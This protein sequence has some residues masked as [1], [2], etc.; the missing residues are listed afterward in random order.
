MGS[1][2][3]ARE[4]ACLVY[5]MQS[6][7]RSISIS[8]HNVVSMSICYYFLDKCFP[9]SEEF[10]K[11][12]MEEGKSA[13]IMHALIVSCFRYFKHWNSIIYQ[14]YSFTLYWYIHIF[15]EAVFYDIFF[16]IFS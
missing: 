1:A 9:S 7:H 8:K 6:F 12:K 4:W 10:V 15:L 2:V 16:G 11:I 14:F 13:Q 3:L 5:I